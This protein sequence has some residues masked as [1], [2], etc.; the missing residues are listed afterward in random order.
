MIHKVQ[1][2]VLVVTRQAAFASVSALAGLGMG[3]DKVYM[4]ARRW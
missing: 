4:Q 2:I 3:E 1:A